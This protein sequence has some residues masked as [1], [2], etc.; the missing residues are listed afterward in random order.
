MCL[1]TQRIGIP[2]STFW[3]RQADSVS[4]IAKK[5]E[6]VI[7]PLHFVCGQLNGI[8]SFCRMRFVFMI[9]LGL[10]IQTKCLRQC[11]SWAIWNDGTVLFDFFFS[12]FNKIL[13]KSDNTG[14]ER[15]FGGNFILTFF[16]LNL[17]PKEKIPTNCFI[18][19]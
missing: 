3:W 14:I 11:Y 9:F 1:F 10:E 6:Q 7:V 18:C 8:E 15:D 16:Y 19:F 2:K 5:K 4:S 12:N 13:P 17:K